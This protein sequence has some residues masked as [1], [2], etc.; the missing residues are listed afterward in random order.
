MKRI[1]QPAQHIMVIKP[2]KGRGFM[3]GG[4]MVDAVRE[5]AHRPEGAASDYD[6]LLEM[7]GDARP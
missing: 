6:P 3:A 1:T 2:D 4:F 7:I 5:A